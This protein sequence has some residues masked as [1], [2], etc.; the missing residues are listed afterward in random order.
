M[1]QFDPNFTGTPPFEIRGDVTSVKVLE[2]GV[3]PNHVVDPT[4][5][6]EIE[7]EW[8]VDGG[9]TNLWLTALAPAEWR[10]SVFAESQG[11]GAE[12][13][14]G[15]VT[16]P[17]GPLGALPYTRTANIV[18]PAPLPLQQ[19]G[20]A[21]S[22]VYAHG[23]RLPEQLD[24]RRR[25]R[26]DRVHRGTLRPGRGPCVGPELRPLR[27]AMRRARCWTRPGRCVGGRRLR[28]RPGRRGRTAR[29]RSG[30]R[31]RT[32]E[33]GVAQ[34]HGRS[35]R[36]GVDGRPQ[37]SHAQLELPEGQVHPALSRVAAHQQAVGVLA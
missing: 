10:V 8:K 9:L 29:A 27:P 25:L 21:N 35:R 1:Q 23:H 22:G 34:A 2:G 19:H 37:G 31:D 17:I 13:R 26:H 33:H 20:G 24:P 7:V 18:V 4:K 3:L 28:R 5:Q 15:Q 32:G 16:V 11:P 30:R 12:V 36:C 14:L 6:L